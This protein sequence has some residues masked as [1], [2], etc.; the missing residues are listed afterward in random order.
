[1][2]D[3]VKVSVRGLKELD[4]KLAALGK[5]TARAASKRVLKKAGQVIADD[6][7]SRAPV[8]T[9]NLKLSIAVYT[10][11][12][13]GHDPGKRAFHA[14]MKGG[15][16]RAEARAALRAAQGAAPFAEVFIGPLARVR[17][18]MWQEFGTENQPAR[19]FM[20]PAFDS[21]AK[22]ALVIVRRDLGG[23]IEKTAARLAKR[24]ARAAAKA[25]GG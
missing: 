23:E 17:Y 16:T 1:M 7:Q 24:R 21:K 15:A 25:A 6:A 8:D 5:R 19:P 20:R 2:S 4:A 9:G 13:K 14:A 11:K 12:P 22:R 3:A 18:A 10:K